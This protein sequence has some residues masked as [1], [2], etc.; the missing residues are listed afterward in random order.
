MEKA[1][2]IAVGV[3]S[4]ISGNRF[5]GKFRYAVEHPAGFF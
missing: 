4:A 1:G 3:E 2:K 5:E